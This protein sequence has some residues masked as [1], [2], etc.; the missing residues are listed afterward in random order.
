MISKQTDAGR[1][2]S[3]PTERNDCTVV[4][5]A[6]AAGIS[7]REAHEFAFQ[8]GRRHGHGL[9]KEAIRTMLRNVDISGVAT[10]RELAT[11]APVFHIHNSESIYGYRRRARRTG[12][13]VASYLATLPKKGRFYL[14][15]TS[16]AF[17][18]VDGVVVDNLSRPRTRA[19][20]LLAY[21]IVPT[22][23]K[24]ETVSPSIT[25]PQINELWERLNKLEAQRRAS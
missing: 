23:K 10:A 13:S 11:I 17:A 9:K 14:G 12:I 15:C 21:E 7:Y 2:Q 24:A 6:N 25:Q 19:I 1:N 5:L 18:Y 22:V 16:H 4:A 20:M 8:V 3:H